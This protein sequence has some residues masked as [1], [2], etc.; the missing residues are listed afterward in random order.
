[1][2]KKPSRARELEQRFTA[3]DNG[4]D[5]EASEEDKA[6]LSVLFREARICYDKCAED[7]NWKIE[8]S[9]GW[10][11]DVTPEMELAFRAGM[12]YERLMQVEGAA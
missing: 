5:F 1:M 10:S 9:P 2:E 7:C 8:A 6:A 3:I 12:A 4:D 11:R